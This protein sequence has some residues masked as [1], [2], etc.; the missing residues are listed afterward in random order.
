MKYVFF[1]F[2]LLSFPGIVDAQPGTLDKTFG[3]NGKVLTSSATGYFDCKAAASQ[4]DGSIITIGE[5]N[6]LDSNTND[7][8]A[9]KY[10]PD[11]IMD[12]SFGNKGIAIVKGSGFGQ[13]VAVQGENKIIIA[14]YFFD[15][16]GPYYINIARLNANG[17]IDSSFGTNGTIKTLAGENSHAIAIQPDD[18]ILIEG[19][20]KG[21]VLT[22]RYLSD[23]TPDASFGNHGV[24]ETSFGSG[25]SS[26]NAIAVQPDGNIVVAGD[27]AGTT[28]FGRYKSDGSLDATFGKG[29]KVIADVTEGFDN[30]S[31]IALQQDGKIVAVGTMAIL[32]DLFDSVSTIVLR[33][34]PD[35]SLDKSFGNNG[36]T[37]NKLPNNAALKAVVI[38]S[39]DKIVT[40]GKVD[41]ETGTVA[42]F[43]V[44]RYTKDGS[45][46]SSFGNNGYQ[47][48]EMDYDDGANTVILQ[49]DGKIVLAGSAYTGKTGPSE[50]AVA[51]ARYNNVGNT[52]QPLAIRIRRWLQHHGIS[53]QMGNNIRYYAVQRSSDGIVYKEIAKLGNSSNTYE[54]ATPLGKESYYRV[55]AIAKD[56]SR[57]Y[58]N[59]VLIEES[60]QV[61]MFPN[62]VKDNLQLQGLASTG[63]TNISIIDVNG[64]V[65]IQATATGST[66][67]I[68]T[69]M[70]QHGHYLVKLQHNGTITTLPFI[71]E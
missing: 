35:G 64:V 9:I 24:V 16:F 17:S 61:K 62:P 47:T 34:L 46:D 53:W 10:S 63:K 69:A 4:S 38:Q 2:I 43:L 57:T 19:Y 70:L 58:S 1:L 12:S 68:N 30:V 54:D 37:A 27:G 48:T 25:V 32:G 28:L 8:F 65:R 52:K 26:G 11:G 3:V 15:L 51:L 59:T 6:F 20:N 18:K 22:L 31:D 60:Q 29:G 56:G 23:G 45:I 36:F 50:Y 7:F 55:V 42:H 21:N 13:A 39:D 14:G 49:K 40:C 66:Y 44:E 71:R 5:V 67:S 33:Y 41:D